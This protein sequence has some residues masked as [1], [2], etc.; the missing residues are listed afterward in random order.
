MKNIIIGLL[1][2]VALSSCSIQKRL[3]KAEQIVR[4]NPD[5][6]NK[7]GLQWNSLNPCAND[8]FIIDQAID[9]LTFADYLSYLTNPPKPNTFKVDSLPQYLKDAYYLGYSDASIKLSAIKIPKCKPS[10][11]KVV[12]VDRQKQKLDADSIQKLNVKYSL[13]TGQIGQLSIELS[14]ADKK[15]TGWIWLFVAST[16]LLVLVLILSLAGVI[17]RIIP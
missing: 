14:K 13:L 9:S 17:K 12:V 7:I 6:F 8:T 5:S 4:L 2:S 11:T 10:V 16:S 3:T 15:A 1:L